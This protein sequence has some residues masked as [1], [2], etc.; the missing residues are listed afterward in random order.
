MTA[1]DV[2][3]NMKT[4]DITLIISS[5]S[6]TDLFR[7][8]Y[9]TW[10]EDK[11]WPEHVKIINDGGSTDLEIAAHEMK[12]AY[13]EL[14]LEYVYRDKGHKQWSNPAVPHNWGVRTSKTDYVLIIDPE[15]MFVNDVIPPLIAGIQSDPL[16]SWSAGICYQ[17]ETEFMPVAGNLSPEQIVTHPAVTPDVT[18]KTIVVQG[19]PAHCCRAWDRLRYI[20]MGGKDERYLSW[21]YEDLDMAHR[22]IRKG[23]MDKATSDAVVIHLGHG[24][25]GPLFRPRHL[26]QQL[27]QFHSPEDG[28]ANKGIPWGQ[29]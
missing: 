10:F 18:K 23:G 13:P 20:E 25:P 29:L 22:L 9:P 12:A 17:V 7:R 28:I 21:G 4:M 16:S 11:T 26:N 27:W 5:W 1:T 3:M 8:C 2:D 14:S 6:R 19:G 15:V 24:Y